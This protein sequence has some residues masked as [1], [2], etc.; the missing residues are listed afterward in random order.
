M[1]KMRVVIAPL[2][3]K[4][5]ACLEIKPPVG[6]GL[7]YMHL[8]SRQEMDPLFERLCIR[9]SQCAAEY[10]DQQKSAYLGFTKG[11]KL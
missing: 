1:I 10:S 11:F 7:G 9:K 5:T 4:Y 8:G 3:R 2:D 6:L